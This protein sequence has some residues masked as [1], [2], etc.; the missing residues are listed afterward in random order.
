MHI[1]VIAATEKE[2]KGIRRIAEKKL[3]DHLKIDFLISGVGMT[4]TAYSLMKRISSKKYQLA[5]NI[6][7]A[8]SFRK[9]IKV[10]DT[11][12]VVSDTFAD[13]GAEDSDS[14]LSV[15]E[16]GLHN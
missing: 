5:I 10:G 9:E 14:F 2:L 1:L 15:F 11:V 3:I 6:G 13:L 16:M 12:T 4:A 8:G 7:L